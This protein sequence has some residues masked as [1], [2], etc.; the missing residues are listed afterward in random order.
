M[1]GKILR[2]GKSVNFSETSNFL[3]IFIAFFLAKT[4]RIGYSKR[5][6]PLRKEFSL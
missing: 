6:N 5:V 2:F 3:W 1:N 4:P